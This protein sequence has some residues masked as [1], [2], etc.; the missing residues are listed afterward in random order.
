ME[1]EVAA[2]RRVEIVMAMVMVVALPLLIWPLATMIYRR[3]RG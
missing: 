3:N 2:I 1:E